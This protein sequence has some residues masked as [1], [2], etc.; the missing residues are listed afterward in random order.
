MLSKPLAI[1]LQ[2]AAL[3]MIVKGGASD[4]MNGQLIIGGLLL[5]IVSGLSIRKRI[6]KGS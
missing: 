1:V 5:L 2:L 3:I 6:S 4:P